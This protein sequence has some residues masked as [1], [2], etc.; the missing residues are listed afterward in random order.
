M[1]F[2]E[3]SD[4]YSTN[5]STIVYLL[6]LLTYVYHIPAS[7]MAKDCFQLRKPQKKVFVFYTI[8]SVKNVRMHI[9]K[10][11]MLPKMDEA[12]MVEISSW[13]GQI[14]GSETHLY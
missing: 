6:L 14:S 8:S 7:E 11:F 1:I 3:N 13:E 10:L 2:D 4:L 12:T 9:T 5:N